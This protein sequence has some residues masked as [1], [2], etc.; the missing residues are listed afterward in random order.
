MSAAAAPSTKPAAAPRAS[1][2]EIS[3][4]LAAALTKLHGAEDGEIPDDLEAELDAIAEDFA[5][6]VDGI[7]RARVNLT[8]QAEGVDVEIKRLTAL[9]DG[10]AARA[11]WL[12]DY[13]F[14]CM[15]ATG[16]TRL[17]TRLFKI[18]VHKN[19]RPAITLQPNAEIPEDYTVVE[20]RFDGEKA[21]RTWL[22]LHALTKQFMA[23]TDQ[24]EDEKDDAKRD[25]LMNEINRLMAE[26]AEA[27][28][29]QGVRV[30]LGSHLRIR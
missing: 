21:Y 15:L 9:R 8:A 16:Q 23:L 2:Y 6:K 10:Y 3:D 4:A 19:S 26:H 25:E 18:A 24:A 5:A 14:R 30:V 12:K 28:L 27:A 20:K 22:K 11:A 13:V 17:D 7:L 1:L 29:P